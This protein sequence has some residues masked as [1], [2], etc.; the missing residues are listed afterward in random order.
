M[1]NDRNAIAVVAQ[2][3]YQ[4]RVSELA[5]IASSEQVDRFLTL[6]LDLGPLDS[7]STVP[8]NARAMV[9]E[10]QVAGGERHTQTFLGCVLARAIVNTLAS[11]AFAALPTRIAAHQLA[12]IV[13]IATQL[14]APQAPVWLSIDN[15]VFHKE[16]GLVT[17]RLYAAGAQVIDPRCGIPRSLLI[18]GRFNELL[19]KLTSLIALGGFRPYF[20]IHTH[21]PMLGDFH[22]HGWE[23]CY[24]CCA[25]LYAIHP[26]VLGMYGSSWFYDPALDA[27][28][29]RL[30]YLRATPVEGGA[31]LF[32]VEEGGSAI[33]NSLATSASRRKLY[34]DGTYLPK[35]YLLAWGKTP[36]IKWAESL[37]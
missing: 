25:D 21:T 1:E 20:Q 30:S 3:L 19:A 22:A 36:Q 5:Q 35:T 26:E 9:H 6:V 16:F 2:A 27:I 7:Y 33:S 24:R 11:D 13:R 4:R 12:Q 8:A 15:D 10:M 37:S 32:F 34:E 23:E 31:K 14:Q 29:P 28:S 17:L 18:R